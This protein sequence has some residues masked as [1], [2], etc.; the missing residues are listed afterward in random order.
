MRHKEIRYK[1]H[2]AF[3]SALV[4]TALIVSLWSSTTSYNSFVAV[5][6]FFFGGNT[7]P[8]TQEEV[9]E[10]EPDVYMASPMEAIGS[11]FKVITKEV[12][13]VWDDVL[14]LFGKTE[15]RQENE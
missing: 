5:K 13:G 8:Q 2:I 1:K 7:Q 4:I 11:D 12:Q 10:H 9:I 15:Y 3:F 14:S 6:N